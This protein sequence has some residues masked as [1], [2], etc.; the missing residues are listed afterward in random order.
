MTSPADLIA[1]PAAARSLG[2]AFAAAGHELHLVG[3]SV[4]DALLHRPTED[5]DFAT[6]ARPEQVL[7]IVAPLAQS[8][9][10]TGIEFGTIGARVDGRM[11][12]LTTYRADRY[13]R[14]SRNPEVVYGES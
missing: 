1:V 5:L 4:R 8:T 14:I 10:T 13:D 6:D 3:G 11:C 12:E 2:R 9:W 7:E